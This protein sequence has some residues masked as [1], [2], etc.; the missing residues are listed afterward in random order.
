MDSATIVI[1]LAGVLLSGIVSFLVASMWL[2][3]YKNKVDN[4]CEDIDEIRDEIREI[5]DKVIASE[6]L[7]K[8]R[9]P[10]TKRRSPVDLTDRGTRILR[11]SGGRKFVDDNYPELK[12]AVERH[13]P[14]TSYD[15]QEWSR[16]VID[17]LKQDS[18]LNPLKE[19]LFKEGLEIS[20]AVEVL[21]IYLR[22]KILAEKG[23]KIDDI[24]NHE[25]KSPEKG[26]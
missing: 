25:P 14:A 11:D 23:I 26:S 12:Q 8:E 15:I 17:E 19:Y 16:K 1:D 20:A 3:A 24:D 13:N 22:N 10:L 2:G 6:T 7:L 5:R 18:R 9:E 21:G 4:N